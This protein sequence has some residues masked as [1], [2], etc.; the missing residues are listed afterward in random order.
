M[1]TLNVKT[2]ST[3]ILVLC[4]LVAIQA[5]VFGQASYTAQIR[6]VVTDQTGA[7]VPNATVTITN[8]ATNISLTAH[9]DDRGQYILTGLRP[10]VYTIKAEGT[11][12]R[13][14]QKTNVV[15]QVDQQTTIN[16]ELRPLGVITTVEVTTAAPLLDTEQASLG[17]DVT[18]E[19]VRDIPLYSRGMFG[20]V[21]LAGGVTETTG[22]GINDNYPTGTN[23][24]SNGQRNAT[25]Q[26]TLDGS[27]ISAPEQGEGGNSNV[28]ERLP[29]QRVV[30]RA[31]GG[32]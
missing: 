20:L 15:L 29:R 30:V 23:F 2:F 1:P 10:A 7:V 18:N 6:G 14:L 16:F 4:A 21:F 5:P 17:T 24:V 25:A 26:I 22:S 19:Y 13:A 8:D 11:G 32:V 27:P 12:F 9:S 3:A 31:A 28:F